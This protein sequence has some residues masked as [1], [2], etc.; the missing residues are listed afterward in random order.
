MVFTKTLT[1]NI[2]SSGWLNRLMG[3][4]LRG[5][6]FTGFTLAELL[7]ALAILGLIATFTIPKVLTVQG[8]SKWNAIAKEDIAA[9]SD[10]FN[11][12]KLQGKVT[13]TTKP[14][15]LLSSFNYSA[16][17]TT[18]NIDPSATSTTLQPCNSSNKCLRMH[19]GSVIILYYTNFSTLGEGGVIWFGID[20]DGNPSSDTSLTS[21][22]KLLWIAIYPD[23]R[24]TTWGVQRSISSY[25][26][27]WFRW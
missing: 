12:F 2:Y 9:I 20:P 24:T 21:P 18:S 1:N 25:D 5:F 6:G 23:G 7:I 11:T 15:D 10:A 27:V 22:E 17:D 26:P 4:R 13:S 3:F 19:N 16:I 8:Y 14:V